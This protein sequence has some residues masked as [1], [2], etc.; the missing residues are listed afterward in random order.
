MGLN[1]SC[2]P[3]HS[4]IVLMDSIPDTSKAYALLIDYERQ[5]ELHVPLQSDS[6]STTIIKR[7]DREPVNRIRTRPRP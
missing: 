4:Q 1:E 2:E 7:P 3:I 5:H 6:I